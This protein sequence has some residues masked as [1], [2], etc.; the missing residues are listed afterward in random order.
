MA[1]EG[2][3]WLHKRI[4]PETN[5]RVILIQSKEASELFNM[6]PTKE[7]DQTSLLE[8]DRQFRYALQLLH[9]CRIE[10]NQDLYRHVFTVR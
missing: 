8:P 6:P 4:L 7:D 5:R 1:V 10:R 3:D 2:V 9:S